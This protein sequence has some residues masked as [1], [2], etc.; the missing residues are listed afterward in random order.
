MQTLEVVQGSPEW[1]AI[2]KQYLCASDAAAMLGLSA[3]KSRTQLLHELHTGIIPEVDADMQRRFNAGHE[4]EA[5]ARPIVEA[6]LDVDLYPVT[7]ANEVEGLRL[8]ASFDG[9]T[10]DGT[11]AWENKLFNQKL[12]SVMV[13]DGDLPDTHWPQIEHQLLVLGEGKVHFTVSDGT[14]ENTIGIMY[15]S[16]P[17]RR[18][19]LI[20]GWQQFQKDLA[21]YR[22]EAKEIKLE[23]DA[24]M[25]LPALSIQVKG[26]VS[27]IGNLPQFREK[28]DG[29]LTEIKT[30]GFETDDDFVNAE[31]N[32]KFCRTVETNIDLQRNAVVAQMTSVD[33]VMRTLAF[34]QEQFRTA[35]ITIE[36]A[37]KNEKETR[38]LAIITAARDAFT[39]HI[40]A[41]DAEISPIRLVYDP[42]NFAEAAKGLKKLDTIKD[43]VNTELA[44]AKI[45]ADG[46]AKDVRG[47]LA[48]CKEHAAGMSFLFSDLQQIIYKDID[49]FNLLIATRIEQHKKSEVERFEAERERI[50]AEERAKLEAEAKEK[51]STQQVSTVEIEVPQPAT[52]PA[53]VDTKQAIID[54]QDE[55]S[56]FMAS[57]D[58]G[59]EANKVR[60]IVVEF[61]KFQA[62]RKLKI[63]A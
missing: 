50:A 30:E 40:Q 56:A 54:H 3:Y 4:S 20:A 9:V 27:L 55:I 13:N 18:E 47:K 10:M 60:A 14:R 37:V 53:V 39:A 32:A 29:Y 52:A 48:W 36:K 19:R 7:G 21:S 23:A 35:A 38:K 16:R 15:E 17:E 28:A 1:L 61:V 25:G 45:K 12:C 42:P 2:R 31:A 26:E 11:L 62:S 46:I 43:A 44:N 6:E 59:K 51:E 63:A 24:I 34:Y 22:P 58:F 49:D 5:L 8:L 33:E 41:L 57:R